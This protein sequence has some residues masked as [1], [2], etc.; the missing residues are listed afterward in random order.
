MLRQ[1]DTTRPSG[2]DPVWLLS[3][4]NIGAEASPDHKEALAVLN[5]GI[6]Q[7]VTP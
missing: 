2:R 7:E 4:P 5:P 3:V 1:M 6:S